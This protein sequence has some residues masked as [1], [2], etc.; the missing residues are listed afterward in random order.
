[1]SVGAV[2]GCSSIL[3]ARLIHDAGLHP[4]SAFL[5]VLAAGTVFGAP[6]AL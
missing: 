5:L 6:W 1:L 3:I 4:I 2:V